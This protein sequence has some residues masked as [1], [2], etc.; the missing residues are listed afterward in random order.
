MVNQEISYVG[1]SLI[2]NLEFSDRGGPS[3]RGNYGNNDNNFR[4]NDY[5]GQNMRG[6]RSNFNGK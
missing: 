5:D 4:R 1:C 6:G 3:N 2:E